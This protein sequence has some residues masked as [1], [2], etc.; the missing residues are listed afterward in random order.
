MCLPGL[1][2]GKMLHEI[3]LRSALIDLS[4]FRTYL[5]P[6]INRPKYHIMMYLFISSRKITMVCT[7]NLNLRNSF[8]PMWAIIYFFLELTVKC[9]WR[10]IVFIPI[11]FSEHSIWQSIVIEFIKMTHRW[12][13]KS[14]LKLSFSECSPFILLYVKYWLHI[15]FFSLLNLVELRVMFIYEN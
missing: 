12:I 9:A 6:F 7:Q 8:S 15:S 13:N 11:Q 10:E 2:Q 4:K 5:F 14:L 1:K 3:Y